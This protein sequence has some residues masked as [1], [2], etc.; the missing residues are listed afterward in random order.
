MSVD[1]LL[2][3]HPKKTDTNFSSVQGE[4]DSVLLHQIADGSNDCTPWFGKG[5]KCLLGSLLMDAF[6]S[7]NSAELSQLASAVSVDSFGVFV[8][9]QTV[10]CF[11][12]SLRHPLQ[13]HLLQI[14]F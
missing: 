3:E 9:W 14:A 2:E 11:C 8:F 7:S 1:D 6:R 13:A 4:D 10:T 12:S 5:N